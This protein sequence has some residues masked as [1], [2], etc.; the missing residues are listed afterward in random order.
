MFFKGREN[1]QG[2]EA[3][4]ILKLCIQNIVSL[5]MILGPGV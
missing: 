2:E 3:G 1:D 5:G 4:E